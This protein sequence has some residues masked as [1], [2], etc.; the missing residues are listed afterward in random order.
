VSVSSP[1][2]TE[3]NRTKFE[4]TSRAAWQL[5]SYISPS[6]TTVIKSKKTW[7]KTR[8]AH[9]AGMRYKY[10]KFCH[11]AFSQ[12]E[13]VTTRQINTERLFPECEIY[14]GCSAI[15]YR[16]SKIGDVFLKL[17]PN[18]GVRSGAVGW[19]TALQ[20]GRSRVR[21]PIESLEF[22]SDLILPV[23]LWPWGQTQP[24]TEM[25]TR[26]PSWR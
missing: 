9:V 13:L 25:S 6:I 14:I 21:F 19:G 5:E 10:R 17:T 18:E 7:L 22:F 8:L 24:L 4:A 26:N 11:N 23:A 15:T 3:H 12:S 16:T 1:H 2:W 20:A